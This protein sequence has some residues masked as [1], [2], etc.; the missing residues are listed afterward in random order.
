MNFK[1]KFLW[2]E[3][4]TTIRLLFCSFQVQFLK[5]SVLDR[6]PIIFQIFR[7]TLENFPKKPTP[8]SFYLR[9]VSYLACG[10]NLWIRMHFKAFFTKCPQVVKTVNWEHFWRL[11]KKPTPSTLFMRF[12]ERFN[13]YHLIPEKTLSLINLELLLWRI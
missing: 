6:Y 4:A 8:Q 11:T 5:N 2:R 13:L 9:F 3:W 12:L 1:K 10:L 7:I